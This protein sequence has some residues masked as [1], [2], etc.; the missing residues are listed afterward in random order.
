MEGSEFQYIAL[1][2]GVGDVFHDALERGGVD[3]LGAF[4]CEAGWRDAG[5]VGWDDA[6]WVTGHDGCLYVL[7]M[8]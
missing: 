6:Q 1:N 7:F 2:A 8:P 4:G 3:F 5:D